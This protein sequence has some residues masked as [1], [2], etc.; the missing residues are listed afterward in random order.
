MR[1]QRYCFFLNPQ[2]FRHFFSKKLHFSYFT[3]LYIGGKGHF[4]TQLIDKYGRAM[5]RYLV[6]L[7]VLA[8]HH[9][10]GVA[11]RLSRQAGAS[12][13]EFHGQAVGLRCLENGVSKLACLECCDRCVKE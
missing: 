10:Y 1:V 11:Y 13:A 3:L 6:S 5:V 7:P 4:S 2:T 9:E 12:G 8:G